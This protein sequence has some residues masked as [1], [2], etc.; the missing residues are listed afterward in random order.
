MD[1]ATVDYWATG[2]RSYLHRAS[3]PAKVIAG[4]LGLAIV[5][6]VENVLIIAALYLVVL[7]AARRSA[8]PL[9]PFI[10]ASLYPA[11]FAALFALAQYQGNLIVPLTTISKAVTAASVVILVIATTPYPRLFATFQVVLPGVIVDVLYVTYRSVFIVLGILGD[12]LTSVRLRGGFFGRNWRLRL[13]NLAAALGVGAI[14]SFDEG[15][16]T[17]A[18]MRV[19]GYSGNISGEQREAVRK[20]DLPLLAV[21]VILAAVAFLFRYEWRAL[22]PF[23]WFPLALALLVLVVVLALPRPALRSA[24]APV[25]DAAALRGEALR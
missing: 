17:Y 15:E 19:R 14:R 5:I 6:G 21:A 18:V 11:V 4:A 10:A 24:V 8:I 25:A 16:H 13:S 22:N 1:V 9:R 20:H 7:A 3:P 12:V 23:S 2:G